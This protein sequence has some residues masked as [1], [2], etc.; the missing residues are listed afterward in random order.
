MLSGEDTLFTGQR[1]PTPTEGTCRLRLHISAYPDA[2][3]EAARGENEDG[4][5]NKCAAEGMNFNGVEETEKKVIE[6]ED[7]AP[8]M[9]LP[10]LLSQSRRDRGNVDQRDRNDDCAPQ[11]LSPNR[12][13]MSHISAAASDSGSETYSADWDEL[14]EPMS[15]MPTRR[16]SL[17]SR[18]TENAESEKGENEGIQEPD[19][20]QPSRPQSPCNVRK[21]ESPLPVIRLSCEDQDTQLPMDKDGISS[22]STTWGSASRFRCCIAQAWGAVNENDMLVDDSVVDNIIDNVIEDRTITPMEGKGEV[23]AKGKDEYWVDY[24]DQLSDEFVSLSGDFPEA[25]PSTQ[26]GVQDVRRTQETFL[27]QQ[28]ED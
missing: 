12:G 14:S 1:V 5:S 2:Q 21:C 13:R 24:D 4:E 16:R 23:V 26:Q 22:H 25:L 20:L 9:T 8:I 7:D 19:H 11:S 28:Y 10:L 18:E 15:P 17:K 3:N 6:D 27:T